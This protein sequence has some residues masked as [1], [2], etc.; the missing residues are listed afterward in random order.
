MTFLE[1]LLFG[2]G[3]RSLKSGLLIYNK[4]MISVEEGQL[5]PQS[6]FVF[7]KRVHP[8][9]NRGH[10]LAKL[11]VESFYQRGIDRPTPLGQDRHDS[12][13]RTEHDPVFDAHD[14]SS[15]VGLGG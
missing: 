1:T 2:R 10:M 11:Q 3:I 5:L 14:T 6:G 15:P 7:A 4:I 12:L 13:C 9:P 8:T